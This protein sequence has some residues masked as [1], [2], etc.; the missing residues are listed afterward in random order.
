[1]EI[2][3]EIL[4]KWVSRFKTGFSFFFL[5]KFCVVFFFFFFLI[6]LL[7][8]FFSFNLICFIPFD[9]MVTEDEFFL[10]VNVKI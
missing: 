6:I 10:K 5:R 3:C 9:C 8:S 1:M 2:E 7:F 4:M